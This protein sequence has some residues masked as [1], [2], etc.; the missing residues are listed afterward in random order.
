[1]NL[2]RYDYERKRTYKEYFFYSEGP[3][4]SILKVVRFILVYGYPASYY[5]IIMGDWNKELNDIDDLSV[6]NNWD[7]EKVLATIAAIILDFTGIFSNAKVHVTGST[8][9]RTRRYQIGVNK[10]YH[11]IEKLFYV[12]GRIGEQWTPFQKN[13]NYDAFF[14]VR[15]ETKNLILE[16]PIESYM[17]EFHKKKEEKKR[18]YNDRTVDG[19]ELLNI[20]TSPFVRKKMELARQSFEK[21]P[22]TEEFLKKHGLL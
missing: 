6:T 7:A 22:L 2:E 15:K 21:A 9:S 3:K 14:I 12:Y 17:S 18:V 19:P 1:M 13:T 16:E 20:H 10:F 4:G 11:E 5:N 8:S